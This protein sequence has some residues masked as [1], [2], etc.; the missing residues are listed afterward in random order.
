MRGPPPPAARRAP[1][2]PRAAGWLRRH[3]QRTGWRSR[4]R[5]IRA[6]PLL[7]PT[8]CCGQSPPLA[9]SARLDA[10]AHGAET[11]IGFLPGVDPGDPDPADSPTPLH[12]LALFDHG[13]AHFFFY[14]SARE[15]KEYDYLNYTTGE[16]RK[17][18]PRW[19]LDAL[20]EGTIP[21]PPAVGAEI[22][23][24]DEPTAS[25]SRPVSA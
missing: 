10:V 13:G 4:W 19:S 2:D 18:A 7:P 6:C 17:V 25:G 23:A 5:N 8:C 20:L 11:G 24:A 9:R 21:A 15:A 14:Q 22:S 16:L 1:A 12:P 3:A